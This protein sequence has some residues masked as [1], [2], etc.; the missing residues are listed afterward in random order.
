ML[1][2][3]KETAVLQTYHPLIVEGESLVLNYKTNVIDI[4]K[5]HLKY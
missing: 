4:E 2:F 5:Q 1:T 3:T